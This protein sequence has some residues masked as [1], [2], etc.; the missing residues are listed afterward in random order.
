[1]T[2]EGAWV[3]DGEGAVVARGVVDDDDGAFACVDVVDW[4]EI[5]VFV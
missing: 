4:L 2:K 5:P 3:V 1:M